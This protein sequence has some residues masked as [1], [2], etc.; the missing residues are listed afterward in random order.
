MNIYFRRDLVVAAGLVGGGLKV[1]N[2]TE[3]KPSK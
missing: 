2:L 1:V 3:V